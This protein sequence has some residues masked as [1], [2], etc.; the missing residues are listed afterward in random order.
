M[1]ESIEGD[2]A[3][4]VA[5]VRSITIVRDKLTSIMCDFFRRTPVYHLG[6]KTHW[7]KDRKFEDPEG[8]FFILLY[9]M[10]TALRSLVNPALRRPLE[11]QLNIE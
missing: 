9:N 11:R 3:M 5:I 10:M 7:S 6:V 4:L 2:W 8:N 1:N